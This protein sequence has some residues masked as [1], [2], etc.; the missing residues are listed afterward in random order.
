MAFV[1][2]VSWLGYIAKRRAKGNDKNNDIST[3]TVRGNQE[4][5]QS[6]ESQNELHGENE[7]THKRI[8]WWGTTH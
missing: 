1:K 6:S 2:A 7:P 3:D 8:N 4:W 5:V